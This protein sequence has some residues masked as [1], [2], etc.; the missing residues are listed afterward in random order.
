M[1]I[2]LSIAIAC[3]VALTIFA[4][5]WQAGQPFDGQKLLRTAVVGLVIGVLGHY[6]GYT[7]TAD[8]FE[9][10]VAANAG[11]I[12]VADQG[13]KMLWRLIRRKVVTD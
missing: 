11:V 13:V 8:N 10:Y 9:A 4:S 7:I 3:G 6:K 12:A 2:V 1:E 5:K